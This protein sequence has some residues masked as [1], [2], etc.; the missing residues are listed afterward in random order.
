MLL[1]LLLLLL[2]LLLLAYLNVVMPTA[3]ALQEERWHW[4]VD[5]CC[6]H[7]AESLRA[8]AGSWRHAPHQIPLPLSASQSWLPSCPHAS[9]LSSHAFLSPS[10]HCIRRKL[11]WGCRQDQRLSRDSLSNNLLRDLSN[12]GEVTYL[13]F[14]TLDAHSSRHVQL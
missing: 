9:P 12:E 8:P 10:G 4:I 1:L 7:D 6:L 13:V 3:A 14:G 5:G 2:R 11:T